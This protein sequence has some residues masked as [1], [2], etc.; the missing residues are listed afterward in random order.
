METTYVEA[1]GTGTQAGDPIETGALSAVLGPNR[2][3]DKPLKIGSV[4]T[5]VGH[6]EAASG[7]TG[8]V[9]AVLMLEN[10]VILP[11]RNFKN[12]NKRIPLEE[13]KLKVATELEP[14]DVEGPRRLSINSF[15][16]GGS[17]AHVILEDATTFFAANESVSPQPQLNGI[18]NGA[19]NG[20][21]NGH[22]NGDS[23][24]SAA[25]KKLFLLSG[26]DDKSIMKQAQDL[27][28]Y[29]RN[30]QTDNTDLANLAY[31][32][33]ER[34]S[35]FPWRTAVTA[36]STSELIEGLQADDLRPV[37]MP[38]KATLG[39]IFTGQGAQWPKMGMELWDAFPVYRKSLEKS[40]DILNELGSSWDL[41]GQIGA[42]PLRVQTGP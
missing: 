33:S 37:R 2:S 23:N 36:G 11:S 32:L 34:R 4:K 22:I 30:K 31:T 10:K 24:Y 8:L 6:S 16:Y 21:T 3:P 13:W 7:V 19:T 1:H 39:F 17:N 41:L 29:L 15:G 40:R 26:F 27:A 28:E 9:K 5:N 12:V 35:S 14:W 20:A 18:T 25:R 38:R 42:F